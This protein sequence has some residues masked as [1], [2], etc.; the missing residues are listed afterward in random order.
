M[1]KQARLTEEQRE[2][3]KHV[4]RGGSDAVYVRRAL[5][6]LFLDAGQS[7]DVIPIRLNF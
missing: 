2:E 7:I 1:K 4:S 5:A 6:V 3:L